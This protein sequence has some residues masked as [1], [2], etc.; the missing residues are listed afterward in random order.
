MRR[1]W[2][3]LLLIALLPLHGWAAATM[4][5]GMT[6]AV[7][8]TA[9][10]AAP[11]DAGVPSSPCHAGVQDAPAVHGHDPADAGPDDAGPDDPATHGC[12]SCDLCHGGVAVLAGQTGTTVA[13]TPTDA[14]STH[15]RDTGRLMAAALERPPRA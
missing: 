15:P 10:A 3:T 12:A 13:C 6:A 9:D 1:A 8:A 7:A 4:G 2:I 5:V 14:P 11:Q